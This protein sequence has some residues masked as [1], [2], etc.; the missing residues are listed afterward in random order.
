MIAFDAP[1]RV[2]VVCSRHGLSHMDMLA[3]ILMNGRSFP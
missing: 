2:I 1:M 3:T